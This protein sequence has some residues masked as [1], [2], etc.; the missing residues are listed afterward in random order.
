MTLMFAKFKWFDGLLAVIQI[1]DNT[2]ELLFTLGTEL[3]LYNLHIQQ[4]QQTSN[5]DFK[6]Y[7]SEQTAIIYETGTLPGPSDSS[8]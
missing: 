1:L 8:V 6:L 3:L 5:Q 2:M 7:S 4:A